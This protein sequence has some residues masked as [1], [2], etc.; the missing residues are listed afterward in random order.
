[1]FSST[2]QTFEQQPCPRQQQAEITKKRNF[3]RESKQLSAIQSMGEKKSCRQKT[4]TKK[5]VVKKTAKS[6]GQEK[7]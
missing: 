3:R 7:R 4:A 6:C 5:P 1:M 2:K